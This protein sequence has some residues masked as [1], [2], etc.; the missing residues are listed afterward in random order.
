MSR[1]PISDEGRLLILL[2][3]LDHTPNERA[4]IAR[5]FT[6]PIDYEKL[7]GLARANVHRVWVLTQIE[8]LGHADRLPSKLREE[9]GTERTEVRKKLETRFTHAR[10]LFEEFRN[11]GIPVVLLK[12]TGLAHQIY[13]NPFYKKSNDID[14]LIQKSDLPKIYELYESLGFVSFAERVKD[15]KQTQEKVA[16]HA[17]P[18]VS[19]DLSLV[20]GTQWGIKTHLGPYTVDYPAIWSRVEDLDF[21][22]VPVKILAPEDTM[23]HLCL[24]LGFFKTQL[25]DLVDVTNLLRFHR[26]R[27]PW[28]RFVETAIA[29]G[30]AS[31]AYHALYLS[32]RL[33]PMVEVDRML[34]KLRP[35]AWNHYVRASAKKTE[36]MDDFLLMS[37][38]WIQEVEIDMTLFMGAE[39]LSKKWWGFLRVW[40]T[41][42][43]PPTREM[44]KMS[45]DLHAGFFMRLFYRAIIPFRV[46][47]ALAEEISWKIVGLLS[48]K[49]VIDLG[50]AFG[51]LFGPRRPSKSPYAGLAAKLGKSEAE[52][53]RFTKEFC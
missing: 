53:E 7:D 11:R 33:D 26:S 15:D 50:I 30:A 13:R 14:I 38:D 20:L 39:G 22:G 35:H 9:W 32:N 47:R 52:I 3:L 1:R 34:V 49:T 5:L 37:V 31:H 19:R 6:A 21:Q 48:L 46:L 2:C 44:L 40:G 18:Y 10:P 4:E 8:A 51:R 29:A 42:L 17:T 28:D 36:S 45:F 16:W 23:L 12:G 25:K 27:F 41:I 43:I 24:H